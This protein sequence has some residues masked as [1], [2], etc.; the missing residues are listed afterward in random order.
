MDHSDSKS[1]FI[2]RIV[3]NVIRCTKGDLEGATEQDL[4]SWEEG[5]AEIRSNLTHLSENAITLLLIEVTAGV[6]YQCECGRIINVA[7][8]REVTV[9]G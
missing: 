9:R 6:S 5:I 4:L 8:D 7:G 1:K 3:D 2:D